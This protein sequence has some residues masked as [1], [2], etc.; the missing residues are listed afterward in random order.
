MATLPDPSDG[1]TG[2]D[3]VVFDRIAAAR[4]EQTPP[5]VYLRMFNNPAVAGTV[6]DLGVRLRFAG[7][8]AGDVREL[9]ILHVARRMGVAYEWAH[10]T[11]PARAAGVGEDAIAALLRGDPPEGLR[12]DQQAALRVADAVFELR[13]V[14]EDAQAVLGDPAAIEVAALV[15]LYRLLGGI[16]TGF[17]VPLDDGL[18][19]PGW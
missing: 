15:G 11:G 4:G 6:S 2:E 14:P 8:L 19:P 10:H 1:L 18:T 13:T 3:R 17:E 9:V 12:D 16:I 7:S 5:Q